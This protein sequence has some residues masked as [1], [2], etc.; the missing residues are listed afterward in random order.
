MMKTKL[1]L[2]TQIPATTNVR[3]RVP[4]Q[5]QAKAKLIAPLG[6]LFETR[7]GP[8]EATGQSKN[9]DAHLSAPLLARGQLPV[10]ELVSPG[11]LRLS[12]SEG[13][14]SE[15]PASNYYLRS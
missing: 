8:V 2:P 11:H 10:S 9:V 6:P 3:H 12:T 13:K 4:A 1:G 7:L 14:V 15:I 5:M